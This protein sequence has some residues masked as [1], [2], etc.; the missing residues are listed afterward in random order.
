MIALENDRLQFSIEP[1]RAVWGLLPAQAEGLSLQEVRMQVHYRLGRERRRALHEWPAPQLTSLEGV[2]SAHGPLRQLQLVCEPPQGGVSFTITF[3]LPERHPIFLWKLAIHNHSDL[4]VLVD[5]LEL[6]RT[7]AGAGALVFPSPPR[8]LAFYSNGWQSWSWS[9]AYGSNDRFRRTRLGPLRAP[10]DVNPGTP[11]PSRA[12]HFSSDMFGVLG[13]RHLRTAVLAGFLSQQQ[14]FGSLEAVL[15]ASNPILRLWANGDGARLDPGAAI[16]IDWGCL[17][18]FNVD[19]PDPLAPY[20]EAVARQHGLTNYPS[21]QAAPPSGWCSWYQFSS[22]QYTGTITPADLEG[23]LEAMHRL[24]PD[25][26]LEVFQIDDGFEASPGDWFSF[27]PA[28][29]DGVAGLAERTRQ[30]GLRPGLWLAPFVVHPKS[31]LAAEHPDWLLRGAFGRPANAGFSWNSLAT[32]LDLTHPEALA[33][34]GEVVRKAAGEWGFKYLKLDYLYTAALPGKR[35]DPTRTRAQVLHTGLKVLREAAGDDVYLLGCGCPL[36]PAIGLVDAMRIGSDTHPTWYPEIN[37]IQAF[38]EQEPN[39]PSARNACQNALTRASL[40]RR[41]WINDPDCLLLR[42]ESHLTEAEVRTVATVIAMSGGSLFVSDD[43]P[44]LPPERLR[45]ATSLL[46]LI[47]EAPTVLDWFDAGTPARLRVDLRNASGGWH[48]LALF[49]WEDAPQDVTVN[50][51]EF[52]LDQTQSYYASEFWNQKVHHVTRGKLLRERLPAHGALLYAVR[53]QDPGVPVYLGSDLHISQGLEV[54]QWD[55]SD[56]HLKLTL[57]RPG[58][59][60]GRL[61]FSLPAP[62]KQADL[63]GRSLSWETGREDLCLLTVQFR[64]TAHLNL[65]W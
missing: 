36:G 61:V 59:A 7:G 46:P 42:S 35:R 10:T 25:L 12:G 33:Y 43:L 28:F 16:E 53:P 60:Q 2:P 54:A 58:A 17:Y 32:S 18:F 5:R 21:L 29:P 41:W 63:D 9:G 1:E 39:F 65:A 31:R 51:R 24:H 14:H 38:I 6:L 50:L 34:A 44:A 47:G 45:I 13:D 62:P 19:D 3:A 27:N 64:H 15:H 30:L 49:N 20:L 37:G 55:A 11:Q 22:A 48:L 23:N 8:A 26:P 52:G 4:P 57:Q 40:H 56:D